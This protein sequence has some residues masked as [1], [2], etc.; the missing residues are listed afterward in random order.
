MSSNDYVIFVDGSSRG[1]PG[2]AGIG[3]VVFNGKD[4][5]NPIKEIARPIGY[6]TNNIAEYEALI[7]A[8]KWLLNNQSATA[9]IKMDSSLVYNQLM[10]NYRI[11]SPEMARL[12]RRIQILKD[13]LQSISFELIPRSENK[14]A[15]RLA[16]Q[17]TKK[18]SEAAKLRKS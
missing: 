12:V 5:S 2:P 10:G 7:Y 9:L 11:K 17:V 18:I 6:A 4:P 8:L 15:N 16:Q 14:R 3:I 1:N 13:K